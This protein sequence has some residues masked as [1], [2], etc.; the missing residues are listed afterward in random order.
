MTPSEIDG[1][2]IN[3]D[4]RPDS[5]TPIPD[6]SMAELKRWWKRAYVTTT[7]RPIGGFDVFCLDGGAWDRPTAVA[8][9]PTVEEAVE[10][11]KNREWKVRNWEMPK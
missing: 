5:H 4:D 1:I 6:R 10:I 8:V 2:P 3:P 7:T 11:A 9:V